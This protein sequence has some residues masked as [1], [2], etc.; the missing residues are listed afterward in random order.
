MNRYSDQVN[1]AA[2][3]GYTLPSIYTNLPPSADFDF[4]A[5]KLTLSSGA[6]YVELI[7]KD[8]RLLQLLDTS[9]VLD[10][11]YLSDLD[12]DGKRFIRGRLEY[13]RLTVLMGL[14]HQA[15]Y[16]FE[17]ELANRQADAAVNGASLAVR[18]AY[19]SFQSE[20]TSFLQK[21]QALN[22]VALASPKG[23]R[24]VQHPFRATAIVHGSASVLV[25]PDPHDERFVDITVRSGLFDPAVL[26][27]RELA[28]DHYEKLG[29]RV[30]F[31]VS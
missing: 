4:N 9:D 25:S 15:G 22:L 24:Q 6:M 11:K 29:M 12:M 21:V 20:A 17:R 2:V 28:Y 30:Q 27:I 13:G 19:E 10:P 1:P 7:T 26:Q 8:T 3:L 31:H 5:D 23:I 16:G 14:M 18:A